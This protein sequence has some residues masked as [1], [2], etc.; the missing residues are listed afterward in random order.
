MIQDD[1][2]DFEVAILIGKYLRNEIRADEKRELEAWRSA[3]PDNAVLWEKMVNA[4]YIGGRLSEWPD[5]TQSDGLW[6]KIQASTKGKIKYPANERRRLKLVGYAAAVLTA[7]MGLGT[8]V[9]ILGDQPP[10]L[11]DAPL[12]QTPEPPVSPAHAVLSNVGEDSDITL[13][14]GDGSIVTLGGYPESL[15]EADGTRINETGSGLT[16]APSK[17]STSL[18]PVMN[19]VITPAARTYHLT[20]ADG[21]RVWLNAGS[22]IKYPTAFNGNE[23]GV[24]LKGEAYFEV[25]RD[26]SKPF[27]V[28]TDKSHIR[29][30]G[31][32]FNVKSYPQDGMD[33]TALLGG[34]LRV[35]SLRGHHSTLLEP[36]YEAVVQEDN[37]MSVSKAD[38]KK[39]LAWKNGLFIFENESLESLTEELSKWYGV[40]IRF[41][42]DEVKGYHFTG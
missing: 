39:V 9:Y 35:S 32:R 23:R 38:A 26:P 40:K 21:T 34:S 5:E 42:D 30:L 27:V 25:A 16:Y 1:H 11:Y 18:S 12:V 22:T 36:G 41:G 6:Q 10:H 29:V 33:R 8:L 17:E 20:L 14:M 4:D 3:H 2:I 13:I 28:M 15:Q 37:D 19:T 7:F 31:T 24:T